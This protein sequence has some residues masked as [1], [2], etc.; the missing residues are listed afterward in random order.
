VLSL[1]G[2]IFR[3]GP[4]VGALLMGAASEV[5]GLQAPVAAGT[6]LG[7]AAS[8]LIWRRRGKIAANLDERPL[9]PA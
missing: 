4:A 2:L 9:S 5:V 3:G 7:L 8:I 6:V 1:F